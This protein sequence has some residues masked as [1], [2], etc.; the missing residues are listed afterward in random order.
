MH[1][2]LHRALLPCV[3]VLIGLVAGV[4]ASTAVTTAQAPGEI[5]RTTLLT[6]PIAAQG[7]NAVVGRGEVPPGLAA[8]RHVHPGDELVVLLEGE[9]EVEVEGAP[10]V[11]VKAGEAM[12]V[13]ANKAH[14]PKS[15]GQVPAKFISVW[16]VEKDKPLSVNV[17]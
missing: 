6:T 1:D 17:P 10:S 14:R 7:Y 13:G 3:C 12:H 15:V 5:K 4:A 11:R 16:I 2:T 9:V 8:P